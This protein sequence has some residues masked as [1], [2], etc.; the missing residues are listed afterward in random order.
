[1][2]GAATAGEGADGRVWLGPRPATIEIAATLF[3]GVTGIMFAGVGPLLLGALEHAGRLS[4]PQIGQAGTIELLTMGIA[5]GLTGALLGTQRLRPLTIACGLLMALF[6]SATLWCDGWALVAVRGLNGLPSGALIWLMT[7][8]IVRAPRPERWAAIYLT[9]QTLAQFVVVATLGPWV[10]RPYGADGGFA[11]LAAMGVLTAFAGFAVPRMFTPLPVATDEPSGI[12]TPRGL[13]A[14][15][16]VFCF[17]A[18]I[19]AVWIYVEPL[20]RQAGHPAGT[21]DLALSLS[22]AAQVTGGTLATF[23]AGRMRWLPALLGSQAAMAALM[24]LFAQLPGSGVF[25]LASALFGGLWMFA[26]PLLTPL[27]IEADPTRRAAV[28]GS[29]AALLGCSAGPFFASLA[30]SDADVRGCAMLGAGLMA[31][32]IAIVLA[33]HLTRRP[34]VLTPAS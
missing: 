30:V 34:V 13:A 32:A 10:V 21:A 2:T 15:A 29:G 26:A 12:P 7:A 27:A 9:V 24:L 20:S 23:L 17:N 5:A 11:V 1:M 28:F 25:L 33:V 18:A 6:N 19:L 31:A 8:M 16:G 4:A 22:L 14:L 3:A